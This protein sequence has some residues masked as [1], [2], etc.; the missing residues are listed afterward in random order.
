MLL[1]SI[2]VGVTQISNLGP[3]C[4]DLGWEGCSALK[5]SDS[6][7]RV[8]HDTCLANSGDVAGLHS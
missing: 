2:M 6:D 5:Q 7:V 4:E 3:P 1:T 8:G